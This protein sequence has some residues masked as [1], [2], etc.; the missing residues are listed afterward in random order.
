MTVVDEE[1]AAPEDV[2]DTARTRMVIKIKSRV[3]PVAR[4]T[5]RRELL[6]VDVRVGG[7]VLAGNTDVGLVRLFVGDNGHRRR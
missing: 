2:C 4:R 6:E 7:E 3:V 5:E 1:E